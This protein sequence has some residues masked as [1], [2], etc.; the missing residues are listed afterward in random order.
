MRA[1]LTPAHPI[2]AGYREAS[3]P[4]DAF[5]GLRYRIEEEFDRTPLVRTR[6]KAMLMTVCKSLYS[7][8]GIKVSSD[9]QV[10]YRYTTQRIDKSRARLTPS[11]Q[12]A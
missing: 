7:R 4:W 2:K 12:V 10:A 6:G 9:K 11:R 1:V 8:L 3:A 5:R